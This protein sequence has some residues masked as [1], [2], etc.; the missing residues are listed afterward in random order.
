M[1]TMLRQPPRSA[2][3]SL[4][5]MAC[6]VVGILSAGAAG[7]QAAD[8]GGRAALRAGVKRVVFLGDSITYA[9]RYVNL[10]EAYF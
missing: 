8:V 1:P 10:V 7:A 9:G 6:L 4:L 5:R 3:K 2:L